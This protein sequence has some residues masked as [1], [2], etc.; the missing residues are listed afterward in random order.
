MGY[1]TDKRT[2]I[3]SLLHQEHGSI[4]R[5]QTAPLFREGISFVPNFM[6]QLNPARLQGR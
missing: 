5:D 6:H 1:E 2:N 4:S 3:F